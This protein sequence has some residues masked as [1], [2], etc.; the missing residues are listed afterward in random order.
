MEVLIF[1]LTIIFSISAEVTVGI[2][3]NLPGIG[4]IVG[5]AFIGAVLLYT[6]RHKHKWACCKIGQNNKTR[7]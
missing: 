6:I 2:R 5:I 1:I 3:F 7:G 4:G